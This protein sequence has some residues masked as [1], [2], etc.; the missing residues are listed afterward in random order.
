MLENYSWSWLWHLSKRLFS[1]AV[2]FV[3]CAS[4][5]RLAFETI[6]IKKMQKRTG[7]SYPWIEVQQLPRKCKH[8]PTFAQAGAAHEAMPM[9]GWWTWNWAGWTIIE[10]AGGP[11]NECYNTSSLYRDEKRE[12]KKHTYVHIQYIQTA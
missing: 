8:V 10:A 9:F 5:T 6:E 7:H 2:R 3:R 1:V 11:R 4:W 12:R